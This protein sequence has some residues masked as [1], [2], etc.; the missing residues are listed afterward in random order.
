VE[1]INYMLDV[2]NP[3]EEAIKGYTMGRNDIAQRQEM[4]IQQQNAAMQQQ[5][6][7]D[8]Q[9]ALAEQRA[10]AAQQ[11]AAAA[12][13]QQDLLRLKEAADAG[14]LTSEMMTSFNIKYATNQGEIKTAYDAMS[15]PMRAEQTT[16]GINLATSL[17][18][19]NKDA[20][21]TMLNERIAAAENS[22]NVEE[23]AKLKANLGTINIDPRAAG[24]SILAV[25]NASGAINDTVLKSIT[26]ATQ[27][28]Q[29][30]TEAMRTLDAQ[31]RGAGLV[32]KTEGGNGSYE[33]ALA[34]AAGVA[35]PAEADIF[36]LERKTRDEYTDLTKDF[37]TVSQSFNRLDA[38]ENTGA[39]DIALIFNYMKMLDPESVVREGEFA[40]AQNSAGIPSAISNMYNQAINGTR[41]TEQQRLDFK[42]Q[43]AGLLRAAKKSQTDA[44]SS[45]MPVVKQYG[46]DPLRVFGTAETT[47]DTTT[48]TP[49]TPTTP[50]A[51]IVGGSGATLDFSAMTK[52][53]L[54]AV[55]VMS[56]TSEQKAAMLKRF[57]E[58]NAG[59]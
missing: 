40:T 9:T 16:F 44:V 6:F 47:T 11:Q 18:S 42:S 39:G 2:R 3:I 1:P 26:D 29:K 23:A 43:A 54:V 24:V 32:P 58:V 56:L 8:Q 38:A 57:K 35:E 22:G 13:Y 4:Q 52:S 15:E 37:R 50:Q 10:A 19:G 25:L 48:E 31:L 27:T 41:L 49:T 33:A 45:L 5:A 34:K 7:A 21:V 51:P 46:L 28:G 17:L 20:A 53:D 36:D 30:P 59:P 55:D 14:A 12:A